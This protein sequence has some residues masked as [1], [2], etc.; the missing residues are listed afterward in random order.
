VF[1]EKSIGI[2]RVGVGCRGCR[3]RG[4]RIVELFEECGRL[5]RRLRG[6]GVARRL[7]L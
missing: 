3:R 4:G 6:V 1:W 5:G 2:C 7:L